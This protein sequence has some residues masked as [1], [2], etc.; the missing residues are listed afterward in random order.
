MAEL[1][2][3]AVELKAAGDR[4]AAAKQVLEPV[5]EE[6]L[7]RWWCE[8]GRL[9]DR[10]VHVQNRQGKRVALVLQ[11]RTARAAL[12]P[13][14]VERL[15]RLTGGRIDP[16]LE[17]VEEYQFDSTTLAEPGVREKVQ[18]ALARSGLSKA[19]LERLLVCR[20]RTCLK[21]SIVNELPRLV[22]GDPG[23]LQEA[24]EVLGS[25]VGRYLK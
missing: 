8:L 18:K 11:D 24:L 1:L 16:L 21:R 4:K 2:R 23:R 12:A 6:L 25:A 3:A 20:R 7:C 5:V 9:P 14:Q 15:R 13:E 10:P 17:E 19:Q 22:D